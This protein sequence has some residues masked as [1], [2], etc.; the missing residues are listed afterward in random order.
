[1]TITQAV[2][3]GLGVATTSWS[4]KGSME[5]FFFTKRH[6]DRLISCQRIRIGL[7]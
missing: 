6:D 7:R 3:Y 1:M 5:G 4:I 2:C